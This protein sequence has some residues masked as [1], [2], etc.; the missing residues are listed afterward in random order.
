M[1]NIHV[2]IYTIHTYVYKKIYKKILNYMEK[3]L[4]RMLIYLWRSLR[5][6]ILEKSKTKVSVK[7]VYVEWSDKLYIWYFYIITFVLVL[8]LNLYKMCLVN[9]LYTYNICNY[10]KF[11]IFKDIF[12]KEY[13]KNIIDIFFLKKSISIFFIFRKQWIYK[14]QYKYNFINCN[15]S[16]NSSHLIWNIYIYTHTQ[17]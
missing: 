5:R 7:T 3:L 8:K 4:Y 6:S 12:L 10:N 16:Y 14:R 13:K 1:R 2:C 9:V 15:I 17:V 11:F